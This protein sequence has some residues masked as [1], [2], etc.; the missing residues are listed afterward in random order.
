MALL[1]TISVV[2]SCLIYD[3]VI[4]KKNRIH[5]EKARRISKA[6]EREISALRI[7]KRGQCAQ[8]ALQ[9]TECGY[10]NSSSKFITAT[11][12]K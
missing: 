1:V 10:K 7:S 3:K 8:Q 11:P 12:L 9:V 2:L 6:L 5:K 4:K